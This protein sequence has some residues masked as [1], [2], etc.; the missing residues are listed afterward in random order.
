MFQT[1]LTAILTFIATSI[2]YFFIL[3]ILFAIDRYRHKVPGILLGEYLGTSVLI[4][5][6]L[7]AA[8]GVRSIPQPWI[9]GL[10][11]LIPIGLG[12]KLLFKREEEE[13]AQEVLESAEKY[14][15]VVMSLT[16]LTIASGGDNLG[17]YIPLFASLNSLDIVVTV[18]VFFISVA[19][20]NLVCYKIAGI[21]E[22][23][24]IVE[25]Y[26]R[27]LVPIIFIGI[28]VMVLVENGTIDKLLS[29]F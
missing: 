18:S 3:L 10:L 22:I 28:G 4:G 11:G 23:G 13:E 19:V 17:I 21:Q 24:E 15:G 5:M 8:Y 20:L 12:I 25:K 6:S 26:E 29:M 16:F 1:I 14:K 9:V 7:L 2:D 27:I